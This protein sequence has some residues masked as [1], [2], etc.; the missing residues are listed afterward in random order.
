MLLSE[1]DVCTG[2]SNDHHVISQI[3][4]PLPSRRYSAGFM[5]PPDTAHSSSV[6][7]PDPR[8]DNMH[9]AMSV[10]PHATTHGAVSDPHAG[11]PPEAH[12][13]ISSERPGTGAT[14]RTPLAGGRPKASSSP[15]SLPAAGVPLAG[16]SLSPIVDASS[17]PE[18]RT[19]EHAEGQP[20]FST[21]GWWEGRSAD[22]LPR[23]SILEIPEYVIPWGLSWVEMTRGSRREAALHALNISHQ[24]KAS[25]LQVL[26]YW[27][28]SLE[29]ER[30]ELQ[31]IA[32]NAGNNQHRLIDIRRT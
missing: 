10:D 22:D 3:P 12:S 8:V 5:P 27:I 28:E 9:C 16:A 23:Q 11:A 15:S 14:T 21:S 20:R 2:Y 4:P 32:L 19:S 25:K 24:S 30:L 6:A 31:T 26:R 18:A 17:A 29:S 1:A 13:A 7:N